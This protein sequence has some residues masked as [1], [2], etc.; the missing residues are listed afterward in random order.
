MI[1][2]MHNDMNDSN[3]NPPGFI[4]VTWKTLVAGVVTGSACLYFAVAMPMM[5]SINTLKQELSVVETDMQELIGSRDDVWKTNDLLTALKHQSRQL[6]RAEKSVSMVRDFRSQVEIEG[7][8]TN[9]AMASLEKMAVLQRDVQKMH[10]QIQDDAKHAKLAAATVTEL[11]AIKDQ[12]LKDGDA[13]ETAQASLQTLESIQKSLLTL[14]EDN[15][16]AEKQLAHYQAMQKQ[17]ASIDAD[18]DELATKNLKNLTQL[19]DDLANRTMAVVAAVETL[20]LL[21]DFQTEVSEYVVGLTGMR[22]DLAEILVL[23]K[24]VGDAVAALEPLNELTNIRRLDNSEIREVARGVLKSRMDRIAARTEATADVKLVT[25]KQRAQTETVVNQLV[26]EP[27]DLEDV[28]D[29]EVEVETEVANDDYPP[30]PPIAEG[31]ID[32]IIK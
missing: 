24:T 1:H 18:Q 31:I 22:R 25:I 14:I 21:E 26:P 15:Q 30:A 9:T 3:D 13:V 17:L 5:S 12:L 10:K 6:E 8:N 29:L 11:V 19:Q 16:R 28:L 32:T 23:E 2:S 27:I 20:E 7:F 4:R